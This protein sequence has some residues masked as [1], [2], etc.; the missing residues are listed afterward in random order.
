MAPSVDISA[1]EHRIS[2]KRRE[3]ASRTLPSAALAATGGEPTV[4]LPCPALHHRLARH[5]STDPLLNAGQLAL[6]TVLP[7][8]EGQVAARSFE[9]AASHIRCP[10]EAAGEGIGIIERDEQAVDFVH[11]LENGLAA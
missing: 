11:L 9:N 3:A 7:Q 1:A 2:A 4:D 10:P 5:N 6:E 8:R